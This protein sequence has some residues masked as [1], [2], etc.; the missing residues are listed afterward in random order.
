MNLMA[1]DEGFE[2]PQTESESGVL[3]LHK[4]S[5][6]FLTVLLYAKKSKSQALV[7]KNFIFS[8]IRFPGPGMARKN[9]F[10]Q[11]TESI[12]FSIFCQH[13]Q[14]IL[15]LPLGFQM[16][17]GLFPALLI[18]LQCGAVP[19]V[20][21]LIYNTGCPPVHDHLHKILPGHFHRFILSG[22]IAQICPVFIMMTVAAFVVHPCFTVA[23]LL[24]LR[25]VGAPGALIEPCADQKFRG[26]VFAQVM[27]DS[28]PVQ[29]N[30]GASLKHQPFMPGNGFEMIPRFRVCHLLRYNV[31]K[32]RDRSR[33]SIVFS[34]RPPRFPSV[35]DRDSGG[36]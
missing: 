1:E 12:L 13:G 26:R 8:G 31:C 2:P 11:I 33:P 34:L 32:G 27:G 3:P 14:H 28:L 20:L 25:C 17:Q 7:L 18:I 5:M 24:P 10:L 16:H 36:R 21:S 9:L 4:S 19:I 35:P 29:T 30:L 15:Q 23:L 22:F 6:L